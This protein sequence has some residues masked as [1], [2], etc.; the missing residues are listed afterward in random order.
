MH[1]CSRI[2]LAAAF[3]V[4]ASS[5]IAQE[6][7]HLPDPELMARLSYDNSEPARPGDLHHL[8]IAVFRNGEYR[9]VRGWHDRPTQRLR[10]KMAKEESRQLLALLD[11][12][13]F[14]NL[15][16]S[17]GGIIRENAEIF[18]AEI[19]LRDESRADGIEKWSEA[20]RLQWLNG[21]GQNPFPASVSKV[22]DWLQ[23]FQPK[24]GKSFD[25]AEYPDICPAGGLRYLQPSLAER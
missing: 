23:H 25:Y 2:L 21:D 17:H 8:C 22:V 19:P 4:A 15:S 10:G 7:Y 14:R 18:A 24:D 3:L 16:G 9:I 20:W 13:E 11:S 12:D 5:A 1:V 6:L